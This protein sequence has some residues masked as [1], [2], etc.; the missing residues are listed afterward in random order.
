MGT[1]FTTFVLH[2]ALAPVNSPCCYAGLVPWERHRTV[3]VAALRHS[4]CAFRLQPSQPC[5]RPSRLFVLA[6]QLCHVARPQK[7]IG[8]IALRGPSHI[9]L[10]RLRFIP[11]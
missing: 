3:L 8:V 2:T 11:D 7:A 1:R 6:I 10:L 9:L 4:L 5:R